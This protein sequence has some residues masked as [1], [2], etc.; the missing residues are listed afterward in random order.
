[1]SRCSTCIHDGQCVDL[2][3]CGGLRWESAFDECAQCGRR[4]HAD[5]VEFGDDDGHAFCSEDCMDEWTA[6]NE[7]KGDEE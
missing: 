5:D 4:I 2:P 7:E 1:M 6:D 3:Y